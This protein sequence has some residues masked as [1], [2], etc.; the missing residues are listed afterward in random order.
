MREAEPLNDAISFLVDADWL[1]PMG[2][3]AGE[4]PGRRSSDFAVSPAIHGGTNG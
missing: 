3:R 4:M 2:S 1:K